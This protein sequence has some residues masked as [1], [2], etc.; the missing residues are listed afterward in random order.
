M[1]GLVTFVSVRLCRLVKLVNVRL[2]KVGLVLGSLACLF[3]L[4]QVCLWL[5]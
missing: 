4:S 2:K 5:G 1:L 3:R